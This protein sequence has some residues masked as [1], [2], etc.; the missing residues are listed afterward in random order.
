MLDQSRDEARRNAREAIITNCERI[1]QATDR[2]AQL[3]YDNHRNL[4]RDAKLLGIELTEELKDTQRDSINARLKTLI[5]LDCTV[6]PPNE[7]VVIP[8]EPIVE[9]EPI[10]NVKQEP[11]T[12]NHS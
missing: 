4:A 12:N 5:K 3:L 7:P 6:L 2:D 1:N 8:Y 11:L 10:P 9:G